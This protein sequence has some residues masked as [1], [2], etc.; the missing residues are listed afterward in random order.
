MRVYSSL[1][2]SMPCDF[3]P[4]RC[5]PSQRSADLTP[6]LM[7]PAG[8]TCAHQRLGH[9]LVPKSAALN[10]SLVR[11]HPPLARKP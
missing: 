8:A 7:T 6:T 11:L 4:L 3:A 9:R 5:Q 10:E 1:M 2:T